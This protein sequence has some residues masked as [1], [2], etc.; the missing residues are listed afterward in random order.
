MIELSH[1]PLFTAAVLELGPG[2]VSRALS[3]LDVKE[4][5]KRRRVG[6]NS[7][8]SVQ[9]QSSFLSGLVLGKPLWMLSMFSHCYYASSV[10]TEPEAKQKH[11]SKDG[12]S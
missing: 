8:K 1:H 4:S 9:F 10:N 12:L 6:C 5:K 3:Q 7:H 11:S 2:S